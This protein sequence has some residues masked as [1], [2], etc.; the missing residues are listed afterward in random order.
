[1]RLYTLKIDGKEKLAVSLKKENQAC[2]LKPLGYD[3]SDMND[4]IYRMTARQKTELKRLSEEEKGLPSVDLSS[5]KICAPV[6]HPRQDMTNMPK[7]RAVFPKRP[8]ADSARI[9]FIFP[10]ESAV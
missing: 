1:M 8:S 7:K 5:V 9:R 4:L 10:R 6:I 2:L 3:F